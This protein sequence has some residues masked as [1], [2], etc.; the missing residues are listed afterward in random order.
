MST[1]PLDTFQNQ[2]ASIWSAQKFCLHHQWLEQ[3]QNL[4]VAF[5]IDFSH[6][7]MLQMSLRPTDFSYVF[8]LVVFLLVVT[9]RIQKSSLVCIKVACSIIPAATRFLC[10]A[11][12]A[13]STKQLLS[14]MFDSR[15]LESD[16]H[17]L[18]LKTRILY[19]MCL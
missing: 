3:K 16:A 18:V 13:Q 14:N 4:L 15:G 17:H 19:Y 1:V 11:A 9:K 8:C 10:M 7:F 6:P 2:M 5:L 12:L